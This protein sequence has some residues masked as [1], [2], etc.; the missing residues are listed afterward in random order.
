MAHDRERDSEAVFDLVVVGGGMGGLTTAALAQRMGLRTALVEA[1]T[2][3]GGCAGYF[4]RKAYAFDVG[5]TALIGVDRG[6][7][8][9]DLMA[10]LGSDFQPEPA[11]GYRVHLPDRDFEMVA[12]PGQFEQ[13]ALAAFATDNARDRTRH[14]L[15]WR[16][17]E[18]L[19]EALFRSAARV[20]RLPVRTPGDFFH[21]LR[22][23]GP[24][25][26]LAGATSVLTVRD[27]LRLLGLSRNRAFCSLI[28]ILLEDTA[29]ADQGVV[30]FA[31]AAACI[32]AYRRGT[33]PAARRHA[34][35]RRGPG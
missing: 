34:C 31:N 18:S 19:G 1:H 11:K 5:A 20:P 28:D 21:D 17:Q 35:D 4:R 30:P 32:Q 8:L 25:G 3:L 6:E 24:T 12:T 22:I 13:S 9:G 14:R 2:K 33:A 10:V 26:V 7:P 15:F 23:L 27:V 29:Q 16:L